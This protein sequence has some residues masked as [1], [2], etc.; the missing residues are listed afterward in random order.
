MNKKV[1]PVNKFQHAPFGVIAVIMLVAFLFSLKPIAELVKKAAD[2]MEIPFPSVELFQETNS[3]IYL[4][5]GAVLLV[6][7]GLIVVYPV[8]KLS[9]IVVGVVTF[10][11]YG[12]KALSVFFPKL[13]K[14]NEGSRNR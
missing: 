14:K 13:G 7:I 8:V 9:L 12:Y 11:Y 10:A 3:Y 1:I 5:M 6:L 4:A 2:K